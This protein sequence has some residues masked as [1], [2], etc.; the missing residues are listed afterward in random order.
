MPQSDDSDDDSSDSSLDGLHDTVFKTAWNELYQSNDHLLF[1]SRKTAVDLS[2]LHPEPGQIFRLWQIYLDNVNPLLKVTHTPTLQG[3]IIEAASNVASI[4]PTL[5]A[6]MFSIY[7][8]SFLSLTDG[9]C[10]EI[11]GSSK[12]DLLTKYQFGCQQALLNSEFLRSGDREC[13]T[14]LFLYLVSLPGYQLHARL[15]LPDLDQ[16]KYRSPV[17]VLHAQPC[18]PYGAAHGTSQR[19]G[20]C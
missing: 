16:T 17:S 18:N 6:L 19:V 14:A 9:E 12:E 3:R 11:F 15:T 4:E 7:C 10:R 20:L 8:V 5:A 1:G 2:T 13:L